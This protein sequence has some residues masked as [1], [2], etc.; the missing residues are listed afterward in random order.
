MRSKKLLIFILAICMVATAL[1]FASCGEEGEEPAGETK[2][3]K[4]GLSA[5]LSGPGAG[6]GE[7]VKA[8]LDIA[9]KE[10]NDKGGI[11]IG[12]VNY[13]FEL[14]AADD[15]MVPEEA[16]TNATRFVLD[17]GITVIWDP[18]ANTIVPQLEINTNPGEE[19]LL[20]AYT[21]IPL[22][23][24][25]PNPLMV[26]MPPPFSV[27]VEAFIKTAMGNGWMKLGMLQT[28]GAYGDLWGS[29][30]KKAW[31]GAGGTVVGEAPAD[32]TTTTDY[33][34]NLTTVLAGGPDVMF[35][36]GP[37]DPT[38]LV[39]E[40]ARSL[41]YQGGFIV[42]DQAKLD[43]IADVTGME[44]LEGSMGVLP[45]ELAEDD[46]PAMGPFADMYQEEYGQRVTWE[47]AI[48]Y[49][50][51]YILTQAM[52]AAGSVDDPMA[53]REGFAM[54]NAAMT[55][56]E[57]FPVEFSGFN[58]ETGALWMPATAAFVV[59]GEFVSG[60]LIEWWKAAE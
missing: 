17:E 13:K 29:T 48:N 9:I 3:V 58:D 2:T 47:T 60:D 22:Y 19:Y 57:E 35:I 5:P 39:I 32:Y 46:F 40:Q 55:S 12:D 8:G 23:A 36:G 38:A 4:I 51:F 14:V 24:S 18:T 31:E 56:G 37:S 27:Y 33:T 21:S 50:A 52:E 30:F 28:T 25:Y 15:G 49:T 7:D 26:I 54:G 34:P 43:D 10:I 42:I 11:K 45:V 44:E 53:I 41:G 1:V 16:L 59:D 6:Y 20:M